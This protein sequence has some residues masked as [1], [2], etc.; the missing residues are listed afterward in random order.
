M[1]TDFYSPKRFRRKSFY[2]PKKNPVHRVVPCAT[3][4]YQREQSHGVRMLNIYGKQ[5]G[6]GNPM[7]EQSQGKVRNIKRC[8]REITIQGFHMQ[9]TG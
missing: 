7:R 4:I 1:I 3:D 2:F 8:C 6:H 5:S 9:L